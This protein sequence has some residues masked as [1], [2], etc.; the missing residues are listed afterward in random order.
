MLNYSTLNEDKKVSEGEKL[1]EG[2]HDLTRFE[3]SRPGPKSW[4]VSIFELV[5][6]LAVVFTLFFTYIVHTTGA[7]T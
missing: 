3:L 1:P 7:D 6:D 2:D 4:Y 5:S